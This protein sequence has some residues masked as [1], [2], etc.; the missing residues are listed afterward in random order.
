MGLIKREG[1]DR[2]FFFSAAFYLTLIF[3]FSFSIVQVCFFIFTGM[4]LGL[5][6]PL[7]Y[8]HKPFVP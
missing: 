5:D 2:F 4:F 6:Y 3:V 1:I 8:L 7:Q